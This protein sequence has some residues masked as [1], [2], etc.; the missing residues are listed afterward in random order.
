MKNVLNIKRREK[1]FKRQKG[2]VEID[3]PFKGII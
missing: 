3:P 2:W 1:N